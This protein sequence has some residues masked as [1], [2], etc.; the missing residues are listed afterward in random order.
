MF[1]LHSV[2]SWGMMTVVIRMLKLL[3]TNAEQTRFPSDLPLSDYRK[4]KLAL[5]K[6]PLARRCSLCA[7][8]LLN[9]AI[10]RELDSFKLPANIETDAYG[11]PYLVGREY[12]FSLSH[13]GRFAACAL[14]DAVIGLDIQILS[15]CDERLVRRFFSAGEQEFIF[16]A[17][18]RD[19]AFTRLWCRKESF[20]KAIGT[21]LRLPLDSFEVSAEQRQLSFGDT[22]YGFREFRTDDLFFCVCMPA[23]RLPPEIEPEYYE[24]P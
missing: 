8:F 18:D 6:P 9:E 23:D 20:L 24:L 13:S 17:K 16:S 10:R 19:A 3:W 12:E 14:S 5:L 15:K 7:E 2:F 11:K 1:L 21:G 22:V 4:K